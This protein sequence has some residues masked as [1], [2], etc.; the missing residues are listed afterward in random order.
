MVDRLVR[1]KLADVFAAKW[2]DE[3]HPRYEEMLGKFVFHVSDAAGDIRRIALDLSRPEDLTT[4]EFAKRLHDFFL[5]AMPHLI[6]AGQ[7]Y[8]FI[9]ELFPEQHGV[10]N[11]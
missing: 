3:N 2:K 11:N 7:L 6:A 10:E 5:H 4:E 9:P 8:D 1:E